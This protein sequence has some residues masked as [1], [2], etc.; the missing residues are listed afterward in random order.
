[1]TIQD[2][3][4]NSVDMLSIV[5]VGNTQTKTFN[6]R[7]FTPRGYLIKKTPNEIHPK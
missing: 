5:I 6:G 2:F 7:V 1:M 4:P 3:E